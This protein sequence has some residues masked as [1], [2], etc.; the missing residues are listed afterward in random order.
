MK[1]A[2]HLALNHKQPLGK[3]QAKPPLSPKKPA[4][5]MTSTLHLDRSIFFF[6]WMQIFM[7]K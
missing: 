3:E 1:F 5:V 4:Q 6:R 7:V 2:E